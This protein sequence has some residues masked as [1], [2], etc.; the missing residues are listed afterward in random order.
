MPILGDFTVLK[1]S[2]DPSVLTVI[3][4]A[5][6]GRDASS[7]ADSLKIP[8]GAG[9][10]RV[11]DTGILS[12]MVRRLNRS[13]VAAVR[14]ESEFSSIASDDSLVGILTGTQDELQ[15]QWFQ[16]QFRIPTNT[17]S[18]ANSNSANVLHLGIAR[19]QGGTGAIVEYE[20]R[21][22]VVHFHQN[23]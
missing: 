8:F 23:S 21:D 7:N 5:I 6:V 3:E 13:A 18:P 17:L 15:D 4:P 20:V 14:I 10:C 22:I 2:G 19:L 16:Q 11:N 12:M 1:M 9:G